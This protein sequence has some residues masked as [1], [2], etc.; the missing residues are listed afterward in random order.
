MRPRP[1][2]WIVLCLLLL[3]AGAW[4]FW[5][6]N[7]R[8]AAEN[9]FARTIISAVHSTSTAPQIFF[10]K[11]AFTNS[12]QA[13]ASAKTNQFPYRL[14]N[15]RKTIGELVNDRRA[16]L[17]ENALIDTRAKLDFSIP[18]NLQSQGDPGAYIVQ[19]NGPISAAFRAMLATAGAQIVSYIPNNAYLVR[20]SAGGANSLAANSLAQ[21]VIPYEPY[22]K[23]QSPLLA[24]DQKS[25]PADAVLNLGLFTDNPAAT[26]QQIEKLGGIILSQDSSPFGPVVRVQPP[27][28]WTALAQLSGVQIVEA[29]H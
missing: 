28:N 25:L 14:S 24:F 27:A 13:V 19:A 9:K 18:K 2:I 23:V 6:A 22:Y 7:G 17:L 20:I 15:T 16:I 8:H 26:V 10:P 11:T 12:T 21:S 29:N 5:Q 1:T 4:L 3:A